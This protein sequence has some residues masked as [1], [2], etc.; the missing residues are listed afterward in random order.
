MIMKDKR[1]RIIVGHYGSGKTE[2]SVNYAIKLRELTDKKVAIADLD[3]VNVYFRTRE[4]KE[5]LKNFNI[6]PIDSSIDV[7]TLD[8]PAISPQIMTPINDKSYEYIMDVGG[9]NVGARVLGRY[10][11][12]I[13]NQDYDMLLV[14]NANREKTQTASE[15][16][17]YID[18]IESAS[19]LKITG[20][21]NNTH[22]VKETS[23]EDVLKGTK[24][25]EEVS[26]ILNI[27]IKYTSCLEDLTQK[28]P[29]NLPGE[30]LPIKLY[31]REEWM[32]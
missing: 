23:V 1:I 11:N 12:L 5:T 9:D 15:V 26:K 18:S 28:I 14:V 31:M 30:I 2:F 6:I 4:K 24:L 3:V 16:I 19:K 10:S 22:L 13:K 32:S 7:Q 20:L 27:P 21:I 8:L 17:K 29:K 25:V